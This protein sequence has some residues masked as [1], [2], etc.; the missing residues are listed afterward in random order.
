MIGARFS[1]IWSDMGDQA[2]KQLKQNIKFLRL[3]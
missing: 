2:I 1:Q 3:I